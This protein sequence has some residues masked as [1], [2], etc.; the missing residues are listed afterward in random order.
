MTAKCPF[1]ND[2]CHGDVKPC[3]TCR[4][5]YCERHIGIF[6]HS[7]D[8]KGRDRKLK[9]GY[10]IIG[11]TCLTPSFS[12]FIEGDEL[13]RALKHVREGEGV[14]ITVG[15]KMEIEAVD[16]HQKYLRKVTT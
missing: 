3:P 15:E 6:D 1:N 14:R 7:C 5:S 11:H 8:M 2:E 13:K 9:T 10:L 4:H 12:I 16:T